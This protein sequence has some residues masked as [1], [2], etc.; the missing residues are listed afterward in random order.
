V[1]ADLSLRPEAKALL[2]K[3][4]G[5]SS[6][7]RA[8]FVPTDVCSWSALTNMFDV[9]LREFGDFDI[10]CPNAGVYEPHW[11]N[12]WHPP[13]SPESRDSPDAGHYAQVDINLS[14]PIRTTQ[15]AMSR[16]L[17]PRAPA[18]S[19]SGSSW[20]LPAKVS[21]ENPKRMLL[22][23][24]VAGQIPVW[25]APIY[26]ACKHAISGFVR[27]LARAEGE[28]GVRV[29]AIAPGVVR[30]PIWT[31]HPEKMGN[32]DEATG[33]VTPE[34]VAAAMLRCVE[35]DDLVGGT[36]LEIGKDHTRRVEWRNDPGPDLREGRGIRATKEEFGD[37]MAAE[38]LKDPRIWGV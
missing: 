12:F 33:W 11:S 18:V 35:D 31:E 21:P 7:A 23:S 10:V 8:V 13:G 27:C 38:W 32:L 34:E 3:Y 1:L 2:E 36:V 25:R 17:F 14:H 28:I 15:L 30:T 19:T 22:T 4:D 24:S 26:G 6:A 37:Q 5:S 9:T 20:P 16:W 29:N